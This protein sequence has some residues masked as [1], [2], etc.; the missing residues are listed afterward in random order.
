MLFYVKYNDLDEAVKICCE[1]LE[2]YQGK[3]LFFFGKTDLFL[4]FRMI[5]LSPKCHKWLVMKAVDPRTGE[6]FY[7]V[8]KCL[9]FGHSISCS[10]FQRFS[11]AL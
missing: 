3:T 9:P 7:F 2:D 6:E 1:I 5:P 8:Y 4:A 10:H 11:N